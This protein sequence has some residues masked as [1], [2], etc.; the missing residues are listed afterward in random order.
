MAQETA[1]PGHKRI[2]K[3]LPCLWTRTASELHGFLYILVTVTPHFLDVSPLLAYPKDTNLKM[4][5]KEMEVTQ[6]IV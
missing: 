5:S 2:N 4:F 1:A 3:D 6:S